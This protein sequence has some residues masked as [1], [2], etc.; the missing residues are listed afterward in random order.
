MSEQEERRTRTRPD[1]ERSPAGRSVAESRA[2]PDWFRLALA[3]SPGLA[4]LHRLRHEA[5]GLSDPF[6]ITRFVLEG[7]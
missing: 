1:N 4:R 7:L 3:A 5:R 6:A 2:R